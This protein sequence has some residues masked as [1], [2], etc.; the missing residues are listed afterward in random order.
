MSTLVKRMDAT[1]YPEYEK[2]WD[3]TLFR[4]AILQVIKA[5]HRLLD[6]GAGA[7]IVHQMNVKGLAAEVCGVDPDPRVTENS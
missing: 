5:E 4:E 3:D 1:F 2:N 7:G 6:L